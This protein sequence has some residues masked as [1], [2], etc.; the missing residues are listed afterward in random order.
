MQHTVAHSNVNQESSAGNVHMKW[1]SIA[2]AVLAGN[3]LHGRWFDSRV[4]TAA[5]VPLVDYHSLFPDSEQASALLKPN[6]TN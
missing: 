1:Q 3:A 2:T 4:I 5:Y 6:R